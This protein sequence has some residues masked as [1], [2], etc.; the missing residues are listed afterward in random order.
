MIPLVSAIIGLASFPLQAFVIFQTYEPKVAWSSSYLTRKWQKNAGRSF[1]LIFT[2]LT[3][4]VGGD[5]LQNFLALVGGFCCASL[6]LI[7][8]SVLH[9]RICSPTGWSRRAD[10]F[11]CAAG[12]S[13][14][15]MST[16]QALASWR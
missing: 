12:S 5:K 10:I 15:V 6:A 8:P 7:F 2:F 4:Q 3:V 1:M 9:L 11:T 16:V 13:I 14:L